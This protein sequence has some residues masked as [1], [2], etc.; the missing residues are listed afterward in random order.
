MSHPFLLFPSFKHEHRHR[1]CGMNGKPCVARKELAERGIRA[2]VLRDDGPE[3]AA[4]LP[5]PARHD[6]NIDSPSRPPQL[7][8]KS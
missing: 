4:Q 8:R 6:R 5:L 1:V 2:E 7:E 3:T